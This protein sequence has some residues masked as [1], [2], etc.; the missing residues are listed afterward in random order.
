MTLKNVQYVK[1]CFLVKTKLTKGLFEKLFDDAGPFISPRAIYFVCIPCI[2]WHGR[3]IQPATIIR[4]QVKYILLASVDR[5]TE[6][7]WWNRSSLVIFASGH[8]NTVK[9]ASG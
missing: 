7:D 5:G 2:P 4:S 1:Y 3:D 8:L 9:Y 6:I